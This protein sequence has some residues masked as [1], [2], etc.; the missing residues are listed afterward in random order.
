MIFF[1]DALPA[2]KSKS[3]EYCNYSATLEKESHVPPPPRVGEVVYSHL[4]G[5]QKPNETNDANVS[6]IIIILRPI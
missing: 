6:D 2:A 1:Q 4:Q 3:H 5:F